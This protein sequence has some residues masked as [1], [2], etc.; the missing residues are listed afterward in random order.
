MVRWTGSVK[1]CQ[2]MRDLLGPKQ[3]RDL[4]SCRSRWTHSPAGL[5]DNMT[6]RRWP[7]DHRRLPVTVLLPRTFGSRAGDR[8]ETPLTIVAAM[9]RTSTAP[10]S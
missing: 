9:R 10:A 4:L 8:I 6:L 7:F 1:A 5:G 2:A 3:I